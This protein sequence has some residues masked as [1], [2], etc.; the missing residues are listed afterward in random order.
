MASPLRGSFFSS[1][2]GVSRWRATPAAN[3]RVNPGFALSIYPMQGIESCLTPCN[4]GFA[5]F[6]WPDSMPSRSGK[7]RKPPKPKPV[8]APITRYPPDLSFPV[9][10]REQR[11]YF[12]LADVFLALD[13]KPSR[14][15]N[16]IPFDRR[17][18]GS[19]RRAA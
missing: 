9:S 3:E 6:L 10:F 19:S 1:A 13:E 15:S 8:P 2:P 17:H 5:R 7:S 16:V 12:E 11:R 4:T 14:R 18:P